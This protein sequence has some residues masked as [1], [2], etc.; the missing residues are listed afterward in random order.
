MPRESFK[1]FKQITQGT[2]LEKRRKKKDWWHWIYMF[3]SRYI[4]WVLVRT[5][6]T[7]NFITIAGFLIG[8]LGLFFI[9]I[10]NN[11]FIIIGFILLYI[12]Y[13]SDEADGEVARYKKQTSL[14]GIYYDEIGHLFFQGWFFFSF[15][16]SIYRINSDFF[17]IILAFIATFFL[18]GIRT[19]RKISIIAFAK[20]DIKNKNETKTVKNEETPSKKSFI[21]VVKSICINLVNGFSHTHMITT[22]F[23][24]GFLLYIYFEI[25]WVIEFLMISYSLFLLFVF[26]I[27]MILKARNIENDVRKQ[28]EK[29][30]PN[31]P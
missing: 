21:K 25:I 1:E 11:F 26:L 6:I 5:P 13:V 22:M 14:Q 10:G 12:Y 4:T 29:K 31:N 7:A 28:Y 27:F 24:I 20:G 23:F 19:V 2:K 8:L 9:C 16:Y 15:G 3:F 18:I 17:Y 30:F